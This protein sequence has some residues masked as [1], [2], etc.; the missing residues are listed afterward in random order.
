MTLFL[1]QILL[2]LFV[3][4]VLLVGIGVK[5]E[6]RRARPAD[7]QVVMAPSSF[8]SP[9]ATYPDR[10]TIDEALA[11]FIRACAP[12]ATDYWSDVASVTATVYNEA[13][14]KLRLERYGW[15]REIAVAVLIKDHPAAIPRR[16]DVASHTLHFFLGGGT[17]PGIVALQEAQ[18]LCSM[19]QASGRGA[20]SFKSVPEMSVIDRIAE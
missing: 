10:T 8:A 14:A 6:D 17:S 4:G 18:P 2:L 20:E 12:L 15:R 13:Y 5:A 1:R 16:L 11:L 3:A 7:I 9:G 19:G